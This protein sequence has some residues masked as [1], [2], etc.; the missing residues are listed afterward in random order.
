MVK[1]MLKEKIE[2]SLPLLVVVGIAAAFVLFVH[3]V[4]LAM[5]DN[6]FN[7]T[8]V[9]CPATVKSVS[10]HQHEYRYERV[11]DKVYVSYS[12][13]GTEYTESL[14]DFDHSVRSGERMMISV[15]EKDPHIVR[16]KKDPRLMDNLFLGSLSLFVS[17]A[18]GFFLMKRYRLDEDR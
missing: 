15:S 17:A 10:V 18:C 6:D 12:I 2:N 9:T 7:R 14:V 4:F 11:P 1:G 13:N 5:A 16:A 8:A 3:S